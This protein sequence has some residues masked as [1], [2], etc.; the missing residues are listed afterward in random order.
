MEVNN[1]TNVTVNTDE[2]Y[3]NMCVAP[4]IKSKTVC[5]KSFYEKYSHHIPR[6][7]T[8]DG[9]IKFCKNNDAFAVIDCIIDFATICNKIA[10]SLIYGSQMQYKK[11][12]YTK[13][14]NALNDWANSLRNISGG[15][16]L[17][18]KEYDSF[19]FVHDELINK[20]I[21]VFSNFLKRLDSEIKDADFKIFNDPNCLEQN[22]YLVQL[23]KYLGNRIL[24]L[25][26]NALDSMY[27]TIS[28]LDKS[29]DNKNIKEELENSILGNIIFPF[30]N[31]LNKMKDNL[32]ELKNYIRCIDYNKNILDEQLKSTADYIEDV[33]LNSQIH[34]YNYYY[35]NYKELKYIKKTKRSKSLRKKSLMS[36]NE[37]YQ[38]RLKTEKIFP[39]VIEH[40]Y[41]TKTDDFDV[42]TSDLYID[43]VSQ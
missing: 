15:I 6:E 29:K 37:Y 17:K 18:Q 11:Y 33:L 14:K 4:L 30:Y 24:T 27:K 41:P 40:E 36:R 21:I 23:F 13:S 34:M 43:E 3:N 20:R 22:I 28:E 12:S 38:N 42:I 7:Y 16:I 32:Y 1:T 35:T 26:W 5:A 25:S 19:F 10:Y 2:R 9:I 31:N 39:K 8:I